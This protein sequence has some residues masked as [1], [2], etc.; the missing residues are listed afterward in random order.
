MFAKGAVPG[1]AEATV[2]V[3]SEPVPENSWLYQNQPISPKNKIGWGQAEYECEEAVQF[4]PGGE[5][6][7]PHHPLPEQAAGE[8]HQVEIQ[9][10]ILGED[11]GAAVR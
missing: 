7:G 6:Q 11:L 8:P 3:S 1:W 2:P 5:L 9:G 4:V 10:G